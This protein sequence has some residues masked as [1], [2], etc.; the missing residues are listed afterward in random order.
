M[1]KVMAVGLDS[2]HRLVYMFSAKWLLPAALRTCK[3]L[4]VNYSEADFEVFHPAG[5][6][7]CTDGGE[8]WRGGG[9]RRSPPPCQ[10]SPRRCNDKGIGPQN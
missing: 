3:A 6:T 8:I 5:A 2:G 1:C 4:V 7:H 10:I 9:D